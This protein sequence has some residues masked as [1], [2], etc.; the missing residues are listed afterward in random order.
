VIIQ[1]ERPA[2][3]LAVGRLAAGT[4]SET[5]RSAHL[6]DVGED[7]ANQTSIYAR[8]GAE[9]PMADVEWLRP[10]SGMPCERCLGFSGVDAGFP[11]RHSVGV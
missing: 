8:C 1:D 5:R 2:R 3:V 10:G 7:S 6:F 4:A 9:L 11:P